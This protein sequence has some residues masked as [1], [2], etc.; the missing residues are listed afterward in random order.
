MNAPTTAAQA[1]TGWRC[2]WTTLDEHDQD[3][4]RSRV[5]PYAFRH[6]YP[7]LRADAGVP[8]EILQVL[9]AHQEPSTTQI[10]YRVSH[11]RRVEAVRAIAA[12]Y[13]FDISGGRLRPHGS[14]DDL[15]DRTRAG[16]GQV[17]SP[18]GPATR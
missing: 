6:T 1:G 5:F 15:A 3:F 14:A 8:L 7:Q 9:M 10:Y 12:R 11:P 2:G 4:D 16:V 18:A 17:P 13:Q